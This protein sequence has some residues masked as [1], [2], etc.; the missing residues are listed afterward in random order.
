GVDLVQQLVGAFLDEGFDVVGHGRNLILRRC[1]PS[2]ERWPASG[3][4]EAVPPSDSRCTP[5]G[6]DGPAGRGAA[7]GSEQPERRLRGGQGPTV[8]AVV[9]GAVVVVDVEVV[10]G[11]VVVVVGRVV[12][13]VV[14]VV[15]VDVV[16]VLVDVVDVDVVV[17][18]VVGGVV[19][20]FHGW[21]MSS[22]TTA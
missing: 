16:V 17:I 2:I 21:R 8:V 11:A 9:V 12:V 20:L 13:V 15:V 19:S 14:E 5:L 18:D 7:S 10:V 6:D 1:H 4:S 3:A 22:S